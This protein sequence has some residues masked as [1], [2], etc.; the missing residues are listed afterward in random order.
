MIASG[1]GHYFSLF[2][3][4]PFLLATTPAIML[5]KNPTQVP[6]SLNI[7]I[8]IRVRVSSSC[9]S[10]TP[11]IRELDKIHYC[12]SCLIAIETVWPFDPASFRYDQSIFLT[13]FEVRLNPKPKPRL[14][15]LL[16]LF[17]ISSLVTVTTPAA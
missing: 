8:L 9:C 16:L 13:S 14:L 2:C 3:R 17:S 11:N 5:N 7:D 6:A 1:G 10:S 4:Q 15:L 12:P